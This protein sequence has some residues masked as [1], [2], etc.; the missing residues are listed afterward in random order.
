MT[1]SRCGSGREHI[2]L[3][4][5]AA[6][7]WAMESCD[8]G[9]YNGRTLEGVELLVSL[10]VVRTNSELSLEKGHFRAPPSDAFYGFAERWW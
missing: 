1:S 9:I 10:S 5:I 8:N 3:R 4:V 2:I 7:S 6:K